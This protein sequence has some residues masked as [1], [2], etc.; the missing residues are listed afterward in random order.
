MPVVTFESSVMKYMVLQSGFITP[1]NNDLVLPT[2]TKPDLVDVVTKPQ[3]H[4]ASPY[5]HSA[6]ITEL[7]AKYG[8]NSSVIKDFDY[9]EQYLKAFIGLM[10]S[11]S[12]K[13]WVYAQKQNST[14]SR[15]GVEFLIDTLRYI[16]TGERYIN[17]NNWM[18]LLDAVPGMRA[19]SDD[20]ALFECYF[21]DRLD[22]NIYTGP[23]IPH[24][25]TTVISRWCSHTEGFKDFVMT[26]GIIF[27]KHPK[28][29][30]PTDQVSTVVG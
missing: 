2:L 28:S 19:D 27:G 11:V 8:F 14:I 23:T 26:A 18:G 4:S 22:T 17:I 15:M 10:N 9:R 29:T 6:T 24:D 5:Y 25:L 30:L 21:G 12:F 20:I 3:R 16:S 13:A 7:F 1:E